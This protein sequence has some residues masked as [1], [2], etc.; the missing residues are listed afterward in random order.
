MRSRTKLDRFGRVVVPKPMREELGLEAGAGLTI[1][2]VDG[3]L[4]L[5]PIVDE[6]PLSETEGLLVYDGEPTGDLS[7]AVHALRAQRTQPG[8]S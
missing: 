2:V 7:A 5:T 1:E 3:A 8:S 4:R 6:V